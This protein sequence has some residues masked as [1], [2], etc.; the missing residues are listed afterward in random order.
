MKALRVLT[1]F[2][3]QTLKSVYGQQEHYSGTDL[4]HGISIV[5]RFC[6]LHL[7]YSML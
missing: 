7:A 1:K 4:V 3:T 2:E 5:V 6:A